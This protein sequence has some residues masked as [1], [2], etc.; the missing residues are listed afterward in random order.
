MKIF[1]SAQSPYVRKCMVVAHE[2][3]LRERIELVP[4]AAHP[5][6]RD[7]TI[8]AH[9]PLGKVPTLIT[10]DGVVLY[11]SRVICEYLNAL[12]DGDLLPSRGDARWRVLADQS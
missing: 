12:A 11:D 3:G 8:V 1:H 10:A 4:A 9:N 7:R 5:I 2:L 6:N